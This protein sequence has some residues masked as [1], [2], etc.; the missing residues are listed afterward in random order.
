[1]TNKVSFEGSFMTDN[2]LTVVF[3]C[4]LVIAVLIF[5]F[6]GKDESMSFLGVIINIIV[7]LFL[8]TLMWIGIKSLF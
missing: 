8:L 5:L 1:M 4:T 6:K 2:F 7:S 3:V